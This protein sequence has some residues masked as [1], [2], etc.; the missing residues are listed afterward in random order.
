VDD[1]APDF[2]MLGAGV[3]GRLDRPAL[4]PIHR[5]QW[6]LLSLLSKTISSVRKAGEFSD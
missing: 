5:G 2:V 1:V 6:A 4:L 3:G